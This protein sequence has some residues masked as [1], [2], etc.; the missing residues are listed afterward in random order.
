MKKA[1]S[2]A[3]IGAGNLTDSSLARFWSLSEM[4]GPVKASSFRLASRIANHLQSRLSR[5]RF[6]RVR[7]LPPDSYFGAGPAS[8][9]RARGVVRRQDPLARKSCRRYA[10][11]GSTAPQLSP[12]ALRGAST[13]SSTTIPGFD[14]SRY[15]IEGDKLAV[16]ESKCLVENGERQAL[17]TER[18]LKPL[19][20]TALTCTGTLLIPL[21]M[22]ASESLR[23]AGVPSWASAA[24]LE[25]QVDS[26]VRS[27]LRSGRRSY[28]EPREFGRQLNALY[29][30]DSSLAGYVEQSCQ[31]AA[32]LVEARQPAL[33][34][35][36]APRL[37]PVAGKT[38]GM[39]PARPAALEQSQFAAA[40]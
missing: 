26:S 35:R 3:L 28:R 6:Q 8:E 21:L 31:L 32:R 20:L 2:V 15:L 22:A 33:E 37:R 34:K 30:A 12:L 25:K 29:T 16:L 5:K 17:A 36:Q 18:Q 13:G 27:F 10:A 40:R 9:L 39:Q 4:L 24:I 23:H 38:T 1:K 19:F 11:P 14:D 7:R